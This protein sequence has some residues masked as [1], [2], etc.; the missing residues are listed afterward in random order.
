MNIQAKQ[1]AV[2]LELIIHL[3]FWVKHYVDVCNIHKSAAESSAYTCRN[4]LNKKHF[5]FLLMVSRIIY[6][7]LVHF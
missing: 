5:Q 1:I 4:A 6:S 2:K 3:I 7:L